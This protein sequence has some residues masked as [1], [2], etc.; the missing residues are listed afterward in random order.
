MPSP[1]ALPSS[2]MSI[3]LA[4]S[5]LPS[6]RNSTLPSAPDA[7][8]HASMTKPSLTAVTA[9]V[10]TPFAL[11]AS[12]FCTK[13]GRWFLWQVGVKAPGTANSTT[14]LPLNT[15]SVLFQPG[16]SAVMTLNFASG[17]RSPTL[18][19]IGS[20]L[21]HAWGWTIVGASGVQRS[22]AAL[23]GPPEGLPAGAA[24]GKISAPAELVERGCDL[25]RLGARLERER[26]DG[27]VGARPRRQPVEREDE[28]MKSGRRAARRV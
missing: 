3:A 12:A 5:P 13:P 15:S 11:I 18:M 20:I 28:A 23:I 7:F 24:G 10:S 17:R 26:Q 16:P 8:F 25:N 1:T 27:A 14:F 6:A 9:M 19:A 2:D 21:S 22:G 4:K